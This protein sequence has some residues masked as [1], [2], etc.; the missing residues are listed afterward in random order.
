MIFGE[1][2]LGKLAMTFLMAMVPVVELRGAIP[3]ALAHGVDVLPALILCI[4]G[5][6]LPVPFIVLFIRKIFELI[7]KVPKLSGVIERLERRAHLK[8]NMVRKYSALGL[9]ILVAIP[10]PGTGAWTGALVAGVLGM[11]LKNSLLSIFLGVIAAGVIVTAI[12]CGVVA[13]F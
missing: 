13:I 3:Y 4:A 2:V 12:S 1:S 9:F 5:N 11:R 8:G 7:K 6:M 10:L